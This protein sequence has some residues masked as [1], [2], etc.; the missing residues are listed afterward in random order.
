MP[1]FHYNLGTVH[2]ELG[3]KQ[4]ALNLLKEAIRL[5]PDYLK[6][7]YNICKIYSELGDKENTIKEFEI[8][9]KL[10]GSVANELAPI[11]EIT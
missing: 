7:H 3:N 6:A 5:R 9:K 8:I 2:N 11:I 10:D 4:Q 1:E